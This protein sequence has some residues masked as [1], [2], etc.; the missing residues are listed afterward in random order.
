MELFTN[1]YEQ[2]ST[3]ELWILG[4]SLHVLFGQGMII[5]V[6]IFFIGF[7]TYVLVWSLGS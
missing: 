3:G 7:P 4:L 6:E 5:K 2:L 1:S